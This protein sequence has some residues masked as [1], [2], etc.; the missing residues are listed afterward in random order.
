MDDSKTDIELRQAEFLRLFQRH[1]R[2]IYG[3]ILS[4][5]PNIAVA[6]EI[7]Q[8]THLLLWKEFDRFDTSKDFGVWARTIAYYQVLT[9]RKSKSRERVRFDSELLD[10]IADGASARCERLASRQSHLIDCVTRL[11]AF[12][13]EVVRLYYFSGMTAKAVAETLG[14]SIATIEKTVTRT[15]RGLYDC[16]NEAMQREEPK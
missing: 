3:Y 4:L 8:E 2:T 5:V 12:K 11:D 16:V 13:R 6:D 14:R 7:C 9:Y 10:A 1:Q 15:R